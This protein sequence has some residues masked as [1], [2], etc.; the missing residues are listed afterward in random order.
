MGQLICVI[1]L[2]D[3]SSYFIWSDLQIKRETKLF[4]RPRNSIRQSFFQK[5]ITNISH[6]SVENGLQK[7]WRM[8]KNLFWSILH[9]EPV[10][11]TWPSWLI[12]KIW[13]FDA[14]NY[15]QNVT[16]FHVWT[17]SKI[18]SELETLYVIY[19]RCIS[20]KIGTLYTQAPICAA[21]FIKQQEIFARIFNHWLTFSSL[22][23]SIHKTLNTIIN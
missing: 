11:P 6:D 23:F 22:E 12:V 17:P 1:V 14:C 9:L 8:E 3:Q 7:R 18:N 16:I 19:S 4:I 13:L 10:L 20:I 15:S 2:C 5:S 21:M